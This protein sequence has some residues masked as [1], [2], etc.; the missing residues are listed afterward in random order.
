MKKQIVYYILSL[1][2]LASIYAV[3]YMVALNNQSWMDRNDIVLIISSVLMI[4]ITALFN[5]G[6][7]HNEK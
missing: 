7:R 5:Y 3:F 1:I 4:I 2:F 6:I